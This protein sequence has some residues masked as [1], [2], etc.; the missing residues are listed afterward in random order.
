MP[1]VH[2]GQQ[3]TT[4]SRLL[5]SSRGTGLGW[6][7]GGRET[8]GKVTYGGWSSSGEAFAQEVRPANSGPCYRP[9][10]GQEGRVD[11]RG[12]RRIRC[13]KRPSCVRGHW[14]GPE[15]GMD[16]VPGLGPPILSC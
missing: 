6:Q 13:G 8:A 9:S 2:E 10:E 4:E 15:V 3:E 5:W 14:E 16:S 12:G 11:Q 7:R 1:W